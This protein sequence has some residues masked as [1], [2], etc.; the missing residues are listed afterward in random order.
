MT[1]RR[2]CAAQSCSQGP[3]STTANEG[4]L[5]HTLALRKLPNSCSHS[6]SAGLE[7]L[8][9]WLVEQVA[10]K[11]HYPGQVSRSQN[12]GPSF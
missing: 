12:R 1:S 2:T 5:S 11:T 6:R 9:T 8:P 10:L 3:A 4:S 7:D